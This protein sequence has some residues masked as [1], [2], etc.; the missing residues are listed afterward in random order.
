MITS[1]KNNLNLIKIGRA[2]VALSFFLILFISQ[3]FGQQKIEYRYFDRLKMRCDS[4]SAVYIQKIVT[5][6]SIQALSYKEMYLVETN[7][8]ID[9]IEYKG[10]KRDG[11]QKD[12]YENG[13]L[14]TISNY[15]DGKLE[16]SLKSY[17]ENNGLR[18]D[19][20]YKNDE[21]V[22][23]SCFGRDGKDTSYY[24]HLVQAEY[25]GGTPAL[26]KFISKEIVY[27]ELAR[28][29]GIQGVVYITFTIDKKGNPKDFKVLRSVHPSLDSA[30][31]KVVKAMPDWSPSLLEGEPNETSFNIPI[32]YAL[33]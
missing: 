16:G 11:I 31:L 7:K 22:S 6:D 15:K 18:R 8:K 29:M 21:M 25:P 20:L 3:T 19:E 10:R 27:P 4:L 17:Y 1:F 24:P 2:G 14:K 23:S 30:A 28:E 5:T 33:K 13:N 32:R 26:M 12:F 9:H